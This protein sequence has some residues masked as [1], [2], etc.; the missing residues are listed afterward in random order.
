MKKFQ[1]KRWHTIERED[2]LCSERDVTEAAVLKSRC[3]FDVDSC[4][5]IQCRLDRCLL[6]WQKRNFA[7]LF[8]GVSTC[9]SLWFAPNQFAHWGWFSL[10]DAWTCA[11]ISLPLACR[12]CTVGQRPRGKQMITFPRRWTTTHWK[13]DYRESVWKCKKTR[14][15]KTAIRA[16]I[17]PYCA[18]WSFSACCQA[19]HIKTT[20]ACCAV[21]FVPA[22]KCTIL[23]FK[24]NQDETRRPITMRLLSSHAV[25]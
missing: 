22:A 8:Q 24:W 11:F 14:V 6:S 23:R 19:A 13:C 20:C 3:D 18:Q 15:W 17:R 21:S 12:C 10:L 9:G 1:Q 4:I 16:A 5:R 7:D 2:S 25:R